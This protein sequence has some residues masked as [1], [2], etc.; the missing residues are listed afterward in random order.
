MEFHKIALVFLHGCMGYKI[1]PLFLEV[2]KGKNHG[3][4]G[5]HG[6]RI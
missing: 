4:L 3:E 1:C 2:K 6:A 5:L